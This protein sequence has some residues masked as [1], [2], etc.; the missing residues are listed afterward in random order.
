MR[1]ERS[2]ERGIESRRKGE[3]RQKTERMRETHALARQIEVL[4]LELGEDV[5]ELLEEA[6]ELRCEFIIIRDTRRALAE[7]R[8]FGTCMRCSCYV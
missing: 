6:N 1:K 3:R 2:S 5:K 4:A 7:A 8:L